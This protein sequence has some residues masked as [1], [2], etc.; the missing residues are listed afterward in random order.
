[1]PVTRRVSPRDVP[2]L[3]TCS[4]CG[5]PLAR[6]TVCPGCGPTRRQTPDRGYGHAHRKRRAALLPG[7]IGQ[8]CPLCGRTMEPGQALDLDHT[9]PLVDDPLSIGDRIVHARCNRGR[10]V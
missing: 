3:T 7:A 9:V 5:R 4:R 2:L 10:P 6:G 8:P 1:M